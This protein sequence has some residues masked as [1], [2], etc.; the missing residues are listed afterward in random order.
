MVGSRVNPQTPWPAVYTNTVLG[1]YIPYP[2]A[3]CSV[4]CLRTS[5][6]T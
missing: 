1:P 6:A 5:A 4:P 3:T 2:A